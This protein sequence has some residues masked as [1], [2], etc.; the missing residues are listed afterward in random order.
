M[1]W[2]SLFLVTPPIWLVH[3]QR[4]FSFEV[5]IWS[6]C[7]RGASTTVFMEVCT[8][9]LHLCLSTVIR[10]GGVPE[11]LHHLGRPQAV[12]GAG[13]KLTCRGQIQ[14]DTRHCSVL[15]IR[16]CKKTL[17]DFLPLFEPQSP[18]CR[19]LDNVGFAHG[20]S[21]AVAA[22]PAG[23]GTRRCWNPQISVGEG[24]FCAIWCQC[25][26]CWLLCSFTSILLSLC[27]FY[28]LPLPLFSSV[29][30]SAFSYH[31]RSYRDTQAHESS[32]VSS[33]FLLPYIACT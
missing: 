5:N 9:E 29:P 17:G 8:N 28:T 16:S 6:N 13:T 24:H 26:Y 23:T 21:R 11:N 18:F 33:K 7:Q 22:N 10:W 2:S 3:C 1:I 4:F 14:V 25:P 19:T 31:C 20:R 27:I 30:L 15:W 32:R 12:L